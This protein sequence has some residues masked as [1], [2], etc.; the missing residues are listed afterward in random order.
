MLLREKVDPA[1]D[2]DC[3]LHGVESITLRRHLPALSAA[4]VLAHEYTHAWL[5]LTGF[6]VLDNRLEELSSAALLRIDDAPGLLLLG[7]LD[8]AERIAAFAESARPSNTGL[9]ETDPEALSERS[10]KD[11]LEGLSVQSGSSEEGVVCIAAP[12]RDADGACQL[13]MSVVMPRHRLEEKFDSISVQ[14]REAASL[15]ERAVGHRTSAIV[16][17]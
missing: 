5:W 17:A 8:P 1:R 12:I 15:V 14:V 4:R 3:Q 16:P 2:A 10:R 13:T 9:A 11:F 7:H 6:P